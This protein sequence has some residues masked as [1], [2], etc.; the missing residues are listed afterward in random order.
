M[1]CLCPHLPPYEKWPVFLEARR[2]SY[3][4]ILALLPG[5][6]RWKVAV[7]LGFLNPPAPSHLPRCGCLG[8]SLFRCSS[9][10][11]LTVEAGTQRISFCTFSLYLIQILAT[12]VRKKKK[13]AQ[14]WVEAAQVAFSFLALLSALLKL[15]P[16]L[17][18]WRSLPE[19]LLAL[20]SASAKHLTVVELQLW[21]ASQQNCGLFAKES[22]M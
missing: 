4:L 19:G 13:K 17:V 6:S 2:E 12:F 10:S 14:P 8:I 16:A 22:I 20:T 1:S 9:N 7:I 15:L 21:A 3:W 5:W 11:K 18:L